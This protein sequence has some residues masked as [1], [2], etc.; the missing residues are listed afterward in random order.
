MRVR[1]GRALAALVLLAQLSCGGEPEPEGLI[2]RE[3][4]I[5]TYIDLRAA[6]LNSP[7]RTLTA[8][9]RDRVLAEHGVTRERLLEFG[10]FHAADP[11]Y[12][13][14]VWTEITDRTTV[15]PSDSTG[16]APPT[17]PSDTTG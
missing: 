11:A 5:A 15:A 4:F 1:F 13:V 6:A 16:A 17:P 14:G 9:E 8:A 10:E 12:M 3:T 2:D 7:T